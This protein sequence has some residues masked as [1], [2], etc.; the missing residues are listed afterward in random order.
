MEKLV[1]LLVEDDIDD[2]EIIGS[3]IQE[4]NIDAHLVEIVDGKA[5]EKFIKD[6]MSPPID[7]IFMDINLPC[8]DGKQCLEIIKNS[9]Q[10][11]N[12]PVIML[13]T[14]NRASDIDSAFLNGATRYVV[15]PFTYSAMLKIL[16]EVCTEF[17]LYRQLPLTKHNFIIT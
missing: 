8:Y 12:V 6:G 3:A 10:F 13:S 11:N 5:L 4:L 1:I 17:R 7:F 16:H 14:S 9:L 15:K 2:R